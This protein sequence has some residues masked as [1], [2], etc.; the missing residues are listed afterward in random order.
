ML[1]YFGVVVDNLDLVVSYKL[2]SCYDG[3][4]VVD[5]QKKG[6]MCFLLNNKNFRS[7]S[8][9]LCLKSLFLLDLKLSVLTQVSPGS[10]LPSALVTI[11]SKRVDQPHHP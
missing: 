6:I 10:S 5:F 11:Q 9:A 8:H 4:R 7:Q 3:D 1:L 2:F